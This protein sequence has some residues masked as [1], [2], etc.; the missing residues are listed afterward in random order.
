MP[1]RR[2]TGAR[3]EVLVAGDASTLGVCHMELPQDDK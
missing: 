2:K 3:H 1:S